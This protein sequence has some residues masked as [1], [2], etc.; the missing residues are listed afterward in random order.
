MWV[1][2]TLPT[3]IQVWQLLYYNWFRHVG[4]GHW[5]CSM[6]F[7]PRV[8]LKYHVF[9]F[10]HRF[11]R[12]VDK[13]TVINGQ[14]LPKG[15]SLEIPTGF[16]HYDP[17]HW[18]EPKKF[19]PE[20]WTFFQSVFSKQN[21]FCNYDNLYLWCYYGCQHCTATVFHELV[22]LSDTNVVLFFRFKK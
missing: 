2:Q 15:A 20:R 8:N 11:A 18:T 13:D 21:S 6:H 22:K 7:F 12:D 1:A 3:C 17:E 4:Y 5:T 10:Y 14:L 9:V 16:L 19:I